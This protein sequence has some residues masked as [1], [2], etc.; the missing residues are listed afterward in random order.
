MVTKLILMELDEYF[1]Q[2]I[3]H[4][5]FTFREHTL[6]KLIAMGFACLNIENT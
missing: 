6:L 2:K 3:R 1:S 4:G 5:T